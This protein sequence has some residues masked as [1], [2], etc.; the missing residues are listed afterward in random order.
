MGNTYTKIAETR[1]EWQ[2]QV[3]HNCNKNKFRLRLHKFSF[4]WFKKLNNK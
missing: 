2:R 4:K 1:N 3:L